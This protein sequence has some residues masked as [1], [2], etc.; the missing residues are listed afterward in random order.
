MTACEGHAALPAEFRALLDGALD[1]I[2]P[3]IERIQG[4]QRSAPAPG[5]DGA[6]PAGAAAACG[7]CPVCAVVAVLRGERSEL[8][9]KAADH[10]AGLLAVLRAALDEGLGAAPSAGTPAPTG[11]ADTHR[12]PPSD[13]PPG[14]PVQ[15][16]T[17]RR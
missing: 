15:R 2:E 17:V 7:V 16:I 13:R 10:A 14:R 6:V 11:S 12:R 5:A 4:Q 1:R 8:A 3:V 9:A